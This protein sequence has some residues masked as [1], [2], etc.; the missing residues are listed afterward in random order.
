MSNLKTLPHIIILCLPSF[1]S[2]SVLEA[3]F[4]WFDLN[5]F[6]QQ[7]LTDVIS[8]TVRGEYRMSTIHN[9]PYSALNLV[10]LTR[11]LFRGVYVCVCMC[12]CEYV[13]MCWGRVVLGDGG[14]F[15]KIHDSQ[16]AWVA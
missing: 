3:E 10:I 12:V 1:S 11:M 15:L 6:C 4:F 7:S 5:Q 16:D 13:C 8:I 9:T 14:C 2:F